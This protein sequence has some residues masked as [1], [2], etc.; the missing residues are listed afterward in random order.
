MLDAAGLSLERALFPP[1]VLVERL[2]PIGVVDLA[3]RA[4]RDYST[5]SRQVVRLD[6]LGLVTRRT[7]VVDAARDRMALALFGEWDAADFDHL[8]RL[9]RKVADGLLGDRRLPTRYVQKALRT[10]R[11]A[12]TKAL[13]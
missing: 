12:S 1:L 3:G 5:V 13:M 4:G 7:D 9:M 11:H 8:I 2:G 6:E 10:R